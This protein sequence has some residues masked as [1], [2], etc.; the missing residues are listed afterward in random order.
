VDLGSGATF[1]PF[2]VAQ[3][4]WRVI[5]LDSDPSAALSLRRAVQKVPEG[6]GSV[7]P[8]VS[9]G[10]SVALGTAS[11]DCVYCISVLEHIADFESVIAEVR[12]VLRPQGLLVLTFDVDLRGNWELSPTS[13]IRL[14]EA[15]E[16]RFSRVYP[17]KVLHPLRV[18]T[19]DNSMYPMY[20][21]QSAI[22]RVLA[23][24]K[25]SIYT[26]LNSIR[27]R[28]HPTGRLLVTTYGG[29]LRKSNAR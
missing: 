18:L 5:A 21:D 9:D 7:K 1:F 24:V 15:L 22:R 23:P 2:A 12:R 20:A 13:Y 19:S 4:G 28:P 8:L 3:L 27:G 14:H 25:H 17:E 16:A 6:P 10:R 26:G 11:V 29:C